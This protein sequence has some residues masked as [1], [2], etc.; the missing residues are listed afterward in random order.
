MRF[1]SEEC[2]SLWKNF[3]F[4]FYLTCYFQFSLNYY[5]SHIMSHFSCLNELILF[6]SSFFSFLIVSLTLFSLKFIGLA[7]V[8]EGREGGDGLAYSFP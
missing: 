6:G 1:M 8:Q 3:K 5:V 4:L 7:Y 2:C